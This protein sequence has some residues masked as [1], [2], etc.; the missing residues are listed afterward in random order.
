MTT[1]YN[2]YSTIV[3]SSTG[4]ITSAYNYYTIANNSST[5]TITSLYGIDVGS[6]ANTSGTITSA[7]GVYVADQSVGT[8]TSAYGIYIADQA[9]AATNN[10]GIYSAGA[11]NYNYFGGK[12]GI[13]IA[14][15][16]PLDVV[17]QVRI[18]N[19]ASSTSTW[20][21]FT[22]NGTAAG[23]CDTGSGTIG[24][25]LCFRSSTD[26]GGASAMRMNNGGNT[27]IAA[28]STQSG[29]PDIAEQIEVNDPSII[30]GDILVATTP[31]PDDGRD[32]YKRAQATKSRQA[33]EGGVL[34]VVSS[35]P[36]RLIAIR[37][38]MD[39][40][41][42]ERSVDGTRRSLAIA[43]RMP[44][45]IASTS[46]SIRVGDYLTTSDIPGRAM[47]ATRGGV[48]VGKALED[49]IPGSGKTSI[50]M[51]LNISWYDPTDTAL[52]GKTIEEQRHQID[53]LKEINEGLKEKLRDYNEVKARVNK[54]ETMVNG[55]S[56]Y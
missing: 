44:V 33:Y 21:L 11:T 54:V 45:N 28:G 37:N 7:Y 49:W 56:F 50:L 38:A 22:V 9:G 26:G 23:I 48:T 31:I 5:G 47:K 55:S 43:G 36:G 1:V 24:D 41:D 20:D 27:V 10:F 32:I 39:L 2:N 4:I 34:G 16:Q 18:E 12:V 6:P 52:L 3:N 17:G 14:P 13:G 25:A 19:L 42:A 46:E 8:N 51:F 15:G 29:N 53:Q 35:D 40:S 30:P